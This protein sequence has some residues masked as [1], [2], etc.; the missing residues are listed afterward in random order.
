MRKHDHNAE[1]KAVRKKQRYDFL[2]T[3]DK[4]HAEKRIT[5]TSSTHHP[6]LAWLMGPLAARLRRSKP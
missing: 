5:T 1:R 4:A 2:L 3:C 6:E